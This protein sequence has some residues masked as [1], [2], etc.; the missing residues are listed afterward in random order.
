MVN[1]QEFSCLY[2]VSSESSNGESSDLRT[3][4][5]Q[6]IHFHVLVFQR[7]SSDDWKLTLCLLFGNLGYI[8]H[9][10]C[11]FRCTLIVMC[12]SYIKLFFFFSN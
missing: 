10:F 4:E 1:P 5:A 8:I 3:K 9:F 7:V 12:L 2:C 6:N 11:L